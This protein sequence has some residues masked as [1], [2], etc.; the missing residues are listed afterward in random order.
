MGRVWLVVDLVTLKSL[1]LWLIPRESDPCELNLFLQKRKSTSQSSLPIFLNRLVSKIIAIRYSFPFDLSEK[2][3]ILAVR[4]LPSEAFTIP[5]TP[6][7]LVASHYTF[8]ENLPAW[9]E[10]TETN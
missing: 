4:K 6:V 8:R 2:G 7:S 9:E 3:A 10:I 1:T 5:Y